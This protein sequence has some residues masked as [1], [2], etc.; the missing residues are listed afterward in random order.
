VTTETTT[1]SPNQVAGPRRTRFLP[2]CLGLLGIIS[3]SY[4]LGAAVVFFD[5]P[6]AVFLKN[7]F[8]GARAW[9]ERRQALAVSP[10]ASLPRVVLGKIDKP[11]K[12]YDGFTLCTY[13]SM[14]NTSTKAFLMNMK[15]DVVHQ[16]SI[17]F[18]RIWPAPPHIK[19]RIND[20]L[21]AF[22]GCHLFP[23][24]DLLI[25]F[26]GLQQ[27]ANGYGLVK[28]DKDSNILWKYSSHI[29]HDVDVG[30][31]GTVYAVEHTLAEKMP[32]GLEHLPAPSLV[33]S[34]LMLSPDG[35]LLRKIPLLEAF[36]DSPYAPLL[37]SLATP[38]D[39]GA[40]PGGRPTS[41]VDDPL[42]RGDSLH[43]N[44]IHVLTRGL[45]PKFPQ[46]RAG[47]VLLSMRHLDAVAVLDPEKG[48]IVWAARGPWL[49]QHDAHFLD[50]GRI[51]LFDNLGSPR[52][53]RVLEY[54]PS[55]QAF[56]WSYA[57]ENRGPFITDTRGMSQ[58]LA[59]G[60]TLI[61]NSQGGELF[62]VTRE[63]EV[64]WSASFPGFIHVGRRYAANEL[65]FLN[66]GKHARP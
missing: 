8:T 9:N 3:F 33:D 34:L 31:D 38:S 60:N 47:Q 6:S 18:S 12:T 5:L 45:A 52:T 21:V 36:R 39:G 62:E 32:R 29:H 50:N 64:V 54:D 51:L 26:H 28:I 20:A 13:A 61:V 10:T 1:R 16:W 14:G 27:R 44:C 48:K 2:F 15:G 53:S 19:D 66:G 43:T 30:E 41:V 55:T 37:D 58:R 4:L 57:G 35:K 22:F 23:N 40:P 25:T 11:D 65:R 17:A 56:P 49:A 63:K 24:G 59:N 7:A 46:F 42:R